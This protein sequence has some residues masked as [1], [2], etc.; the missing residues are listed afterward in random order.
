MLNVR[1][2][3][4]NFTFDFSDIKKYEQKNSKIAVMAGN[5]TRSFLKYIDDKKQLR[6]TKFLGIA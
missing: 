3:M 4:A 1:S 5:P 6:I 2:Q